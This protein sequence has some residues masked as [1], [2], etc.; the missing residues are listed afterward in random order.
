MLFYSK[1]R[2]DAL[3]DEIL[4][5]II[6]DEYL[7]SIFIKSV[8][9]VECL[10]PT[11]KLIYKKVLAYEKEHK[12]PP[13][14]AEAD[15]LFE[16]TINTS[17]LG[18]DFTFEFVL[19]EIKNEKLK[20]WILTVAT[21]IE[22]HEVDYSK[23]FA[24]LGRL[25]DKLEVRVPKGTKAG[26]QID[27]IIE[28]ETAK[29]KT[30][31]M[32]SFINALDRALF[33]GFHK[34]ELAFM[35]T[36]PGRGKSTF[37]VN[38]LY[39]FLMQN[40][41]T[42]FLSNELRTEVVLARLYRRIMQMD[43]KDFSNENKV[44]IVKHL[45]KFFNYV[46]GSG[47]VHYVPVNQWG[48]EDLKAWT[49]AWE[50]QYERKIDCI[51]IDYFDRLRKPWGEGERFKQRA[52][53]DSLRDFAVDQNLFIATATQTNRSGLNTPLVTEEH[54]GEAFAKIESADVILSLSQSVQEK[55]DQR[56]RITVLKNREFG[57]VGTIVDVK[58]IWEELTV[59]D[60][61]FME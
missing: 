29:V 16:R 10:N 1:E 19:E 15:T 21:D 46:K 26:D 28:L 25:K 49:S 39:G 9:I 22:A 6:T 36:P 43:R 4:H 45:E 41:C 8:G 7:F 51:V 52:L 2:I 58:T 33:G 14:P 59:T 5:K 30:D 44:K 11:Q 32:R 27:N 50:K 23:V 57:G 42:L 20:Y 48:V 3:K 24:E 37:L 61:E 55:A 40:R 54:V 38:L 13:T 12:K 35:I 17:N 34:G 31:T 47:V 60:F 53:V 18:L 56:A